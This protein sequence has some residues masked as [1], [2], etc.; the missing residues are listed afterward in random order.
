MNREIKFR[1]WDAQNKKMIRFEDEE[2]DCIDM[3]PYK[4]QIKQDDDVEAEQAMVDYH[5]DHD[6]KMGREHQ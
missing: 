4:R 2:S 5:T 6:Y 1:L 3:C